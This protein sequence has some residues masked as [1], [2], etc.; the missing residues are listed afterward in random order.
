MTP[1]EILSK[2]KDDILPQ[3]QGVTKITIETGLTRMINQLSFMAGQSIISKVNTNFEP[4]TNFMGTK[5]NVTPVVTPEILTPTEDEKKKFVGKVLDLERELP[6]LTNEQ[7]R[8]RYSGPGDDK[9]VRGVAKRAGMEDFRDA[10]INDEY[11]DDVRD[12]LKEKNSQAEKV[13]STNAKI[14]ESTD[15]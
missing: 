13:K 7:V 2:A 15:K 14:N 8:E 6:L 11:L 4:V 1:I 5:V 9:I 10:I 3:L 12:A